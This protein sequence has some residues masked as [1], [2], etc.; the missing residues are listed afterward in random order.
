M[1]LKANILKAVF[2]VGWKIPLAYLA[3]IKRYAKN[4]EKY[5]IDLKYG[6]LRKLV[7]KLTDD[8]DVELFVSGVENV[9]NETVCFF[10]NHGGAY[11]PVCFI[12]TFKNPMTFLAKSELEKAP[13]AGKAI[14]AI[15]GLFLK[16]DDLK[17]SLRTMMEI[18]EDLKAHRK[19]WLIF[20]E[21]TRNKD[22][23]ANLLEFHHGTFRPAVKAQVPLVPAAVF[24]T[25]RIFDKV[26]N[27]KKYPV[28][29]VFG[30][31]IYP[32]EYKDMSTQEI[33]VMVQSRIQTILTYEIR[34]N[35]RAYLK[36][37]LGDDFKENI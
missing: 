3:W 15:E 17:Q 13:F 22:S 7:S 25:Y 30:K 21:G 5:P 28:H 32:D 29:L 4:K 14:K 33:A 34:K 8:L 19:N 2:K 6:K 23:R 27:L 26:S 20:P 18:E 1:K 12:K 35:D 11:D 10:S 16:R 31:P 24:G 37:L 9:P 36:K